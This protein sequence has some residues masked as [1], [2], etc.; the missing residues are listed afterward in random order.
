VDLLD[1]AVYRFLS[2]RGEAR[3]WAGRR[4]IDP[5]IKAGEIAKHV[6]ISESGVR[7]RLRGLAKKGYLRGMAVIPNPTLFGARLYVADVPLKGV[8]GVERIFRDLALVEGVVFARDTLDE[9]DRQIQVHFVAENETVAGRRASLLRRLSPSNEL[10]GPRP[11]WIP[12]CEL[13]PSH[14]EWRMI[15]SVWSHPDMTITEIA[16][17]L[18]ISPK[19]AARRYHELIGAR[20]CWWTHGPRSEEFPLALLQ[21]EVRDPTLRDAVAGKI[22]RAATAWMPVPNEGLGLEP[23]GSHTLIAGLVPADAPTLLEKFV[24]KCVGMPGVV[25]LRRTFPLGST[26]Y[27][28]WF[29][30]RIGQALHPAF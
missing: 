15:H 28:E 17:A 3:F 25:N 6:G 10:R 7:A 14:L 23:G 30:D 18:R 21:I 20:A 8:T 24:K 1:F 11:Y 22:L 9:G 26:A 2:P 5:T 29:A 12:P 27:P 19:T 13:E 16:R 4:L